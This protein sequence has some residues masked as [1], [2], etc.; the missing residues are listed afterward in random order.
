[1]AANTQESP[2]FH[3]MNIM[4]VFHSTPFQ[5]M[6]MNSSNI[7][8]LVKELKIWIIRNSAV[9]NFKGFSSAYTEWLARGSVYSNTTLVA[10]EKVLETGILFLSLH[11]F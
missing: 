9:E 6:G 11:S 10:Y 3:E 7:K 8:F 2:T 5:K 1:M 4:K